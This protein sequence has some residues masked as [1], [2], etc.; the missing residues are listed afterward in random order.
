MEYYPY[1]KL[2]S[3][4]DNILARFRLGVADRLMKKEIDIRIIIY[5]IF[6]HSLQYNQDSNDM[7]IDSF[8]HIRI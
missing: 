1:N 8:L 5:Y 3:D 4:E 6:I 2:I 7:D